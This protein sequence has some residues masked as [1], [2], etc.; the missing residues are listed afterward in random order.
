METSVH[1]FFRF[2]AIGWATR[3]IPLRRERSS[4]DGNIVEKVHHAAVPNLDIAPTRLAD[5]SLGRR[6]K[7]LAPT[8]QR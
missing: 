5:N 8:E 3:L 4:V 6:D 7:D 2:V 1:P